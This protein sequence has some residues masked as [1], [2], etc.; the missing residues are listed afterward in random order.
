MYH[1]VHL[2]LLEPQNKV[3]QEWSGDGRR[4]L[5]GRRGRKCGIQMATNETDHHHPEKVSM[6]RASLSKINQCGLAIA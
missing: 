3:N 1:L 6:K 4:E 5:E 2:W